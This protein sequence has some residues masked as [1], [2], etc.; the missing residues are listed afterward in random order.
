MKEKTEGETTRSNK[1]VNES[2]MEEILPDNFVQCKLLSR[3]L[4]E[5]RSKKLREE[6]N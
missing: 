4:E 3:K 2:D 5:T 1:S 6:T